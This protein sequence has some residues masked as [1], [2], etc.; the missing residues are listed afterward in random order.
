MFDCEQQPLSEVS[1]VFHFGD[2]TK[3][4]RY[5][6]FLELLQKNFIFFL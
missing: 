3:S 5:E 4:M 2:S 1:V 6:M